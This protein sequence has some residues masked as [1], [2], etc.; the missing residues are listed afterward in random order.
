M[1]ELNYQKA[2][3]RFTIENNA[4]YIDKIAEHI[5]GEKKAVAKALHSTYIIIIC[6]LFI[7]YSIYN[8]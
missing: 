2:V 7:I 6:L 1:N 5:V 8:V 3:V 4:D